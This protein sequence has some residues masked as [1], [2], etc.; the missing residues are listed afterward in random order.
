MK[1]IL[2]KGIVALFVLAFVM[3]FAFAIGQL[4]FSTQAEGTAYADET[5]EIDTNQSI[6]TYT[7]GCVTI[8]VTDAGDG[9]G[10]F[11]DDNRFMVISV[12]GNVVIKN[13]KVR[14]GYYYERAG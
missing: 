1:K 7:S 11:V 3:T 12:S 10:A 6:F 8:T 2:T 13:V 4:T 14:I 9:D 5:I